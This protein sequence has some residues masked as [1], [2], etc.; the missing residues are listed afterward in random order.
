MP[1]V[2]VVSEPHALH[3]HTGGVRQYLGVHEISSSTF[4]LEQR[5]FPARCIQTSLVIF[6]AS[7]IFLLWPLYLAREL[8]GGGVTA[9]ALFLMIV[10]MLAVLYGFYF[11]MWMRTYTFFFFREYIDLAEGVFRRVERRL[12][13]AGIYRVYVQQ[14]MFERLF[15][16]AHVC[17]ESG[18]GMSLMD[19]DDTAKV[20]IPGQTMQHAHELVHYIEK[21]LHARP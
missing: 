14:G 20:I 13:Y 9:F 12:P 21:I 8:V 4:P 5:L 17:I 1:N 16:I 15:G 3:A 18:S 19:G 7:L 6:F 2:S 11:R 10:C